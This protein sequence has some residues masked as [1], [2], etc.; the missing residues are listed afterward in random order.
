LPLRNLRNQTRGGWHI[1]TH[2]TACQNGRHRTRYADRSATL[3]GG[4]RGEC[5][6]GR[7]VLQLV[8]VTDVE[9]AIEE[10]KTLHLAH[11]QDHVSVRGEHEAAAAFGPYLLAI[12][13]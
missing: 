11:P 5:L 7:V 2:N 9:P 1:A 8:E 13:L 4:P 10:P 12:E 6:A 3:E